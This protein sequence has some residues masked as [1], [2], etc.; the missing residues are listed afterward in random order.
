MKQTFTPKKTGI[1]M[2]LSLLL[3]FS[4]AFAYQSGMNGF[5]A[6]GKKHG[7]WKVTGDMQ[8]DPAFTPN[9]VVEEGEYA[10]GKRQGLWVRYFPNGNKKNEITYLNDK[11]TGPYKEYYEN[12]NIQEESTWVPTRGSGK[13]VGVHKRYHPN[14]QLHQ[15]YF[16]NE[17][18]VKDG[19]QKVYHENGKIAVEWTE[20]NGKEEGVVKHY[21]EKGKLKKQR[22]MAGGQLVEGSIKEFTPA[23]AAT[24]VP[25]ADETKK[26]DKEN[27]TVN[28]ADV[29][30]PN[31]YNITYNNDKLIWKKG[32]FKD[33]NLWNG[34]NYVYKRNGVIKQVEVYRNGKYI[35]NRQL[36]DWEKK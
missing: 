9:A 20:V 18:G 33:G 8:S 25:V 32:D 21:D 17:M 4:T 22:E 13:N 36:N 12:G 2:V 24:V 27:G 34:E 35:G 30:R 1:A 11:P 16:Y 10:N 26:P 29:F 7:K 31:G 28:E 23:P 3:C 14:G 19:E 6:E 5:D 15:E